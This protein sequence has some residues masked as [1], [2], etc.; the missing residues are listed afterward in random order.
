M[1]ESY[2]DEPHG[3]GAPPSLRIYDT[4][5]VTADDLADELL[6]LAAELQ[7]VA[8]AIRRSNI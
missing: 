1:T 6:R 7:R 8:E 2:I 4:A 5:V 3:R